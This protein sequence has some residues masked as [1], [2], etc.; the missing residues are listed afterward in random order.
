[1][2]ALVTVPAILDY[3]RLTPLTEN[4]SRVPAEILKGKGPCNPG[5][6]YKPSSQYLKAML[7]K[8]RNCQ[9]CGW[10]WAYKWRQ[11]LAAKMEYDTDLKKA[12]KADKALTLTFA[13]NLPYKNV[14][15]AI[16]FFWR[17]MRRAYPKCH[18]WGVVEFNQKHTLPHLHFILSGAPYLEVDYIDYAW[19]KAQKWAGF[20]QIAWNIRIEKIRKN[21]QAYFTKY[22][23]KLVDGGKDEV[24]RRE[25]W[26]GRFVR[27]SRG[28]FPVSVPA[29][30]AAR[31][32]CRELAEDKTLENIYSHVRRPLAGLSGFMERADMMENKIFLIVNGTWTPWMDA[33]RAS[34]AENPQKTIKIDYLDD[35]GALG[36]VLKIS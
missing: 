23:T 4:D 3:I 13:E 27:Y 10:Y 36:G 20:T 15:R 16:E 14:T 18:Y 28:F 22:V 21:I 35:Q 33:G 12:Y 26:G 34:P 5:W 11:A 24:P 17:T 6:I 2:E 7:C 19:A 8:R 29:M 25:N 32:F 31:N 30:L 9:D 1:M